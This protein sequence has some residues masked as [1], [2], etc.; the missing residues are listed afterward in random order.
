MEMLCSFGGDK[1]E[2]CPVVIKFNYV[3]SCPSFDIIYLG[4]ALNDF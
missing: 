3:R 2:F 1:H 4:I